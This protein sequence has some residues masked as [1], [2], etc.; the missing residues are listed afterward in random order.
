MNTSP[1]PDPVV[2]ALTEI[3]SMLADLIRQRAVK[4]WYTTAEVAKILG[5]ETV[6]R[7]RVVPARPGEL[8][9]EG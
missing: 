9:E 8:P 5:Q 1:E 4:E 2:T 3:K 7:P 6:H